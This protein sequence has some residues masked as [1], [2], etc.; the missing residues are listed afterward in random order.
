MAS[1]PWGNPANANWPPHP[2]LVNAA[3]N[4]L[5]GGGG[6]GGTGNPHFGGQQPPQP[7]GGDPMTALSTKVTGAFVWLGFLT[8]GFAGAFLYLIGDLSSIRRDVA[9]IQSASA[10]QAATT[11]AI[12][13]TLGR[14]EDKL[15][16][17]D[18]H[19]QTG[20]R[21]GQNG[22]VPSAAGNSTGGQ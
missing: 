10:A 7:P 6:F 9:S 1:N 12:Q 4:P 19:T 2:S 14:I 11:A 18:D 3:G 15:D 13:T 16:R 20:P 22:G 17:Q 5:S 21:A 8:L